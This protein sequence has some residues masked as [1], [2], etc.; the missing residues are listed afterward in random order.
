MEDGRI[1]VAGGG[2]GSD[3]SAEIFVPATG[4]FV[5]PQGQ[6]LER[7]IFHAAALTRTGTVLLAGGGPAQAEQYDPAQ[8]AFL[9]AGSNPVYGLA[10]TDS[11]LFLTL[12]PIPGKR[13]VQ[14]GGFAADGAGPGLGLVLDQ[15]QVWA[16]TGLSATGAFYRMFFDLAVPRAAHTVTPLS[17]GRFLVVGGFGT[18]ENTHEKRTTIFM[19]SQ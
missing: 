15:V 5:L 2:A 7:R 16:A 12:T 13:I 6:P 11:P 17:D 3:K 19:P 18:T 10:T 4:T 9:P 1:L 14:I 8:D